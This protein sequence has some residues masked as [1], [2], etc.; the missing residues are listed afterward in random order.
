LSII[1]YEYE[2]CE[3]IIKEGVKRLLQRDLNYLAKYWEY[4]GENRENI[5]KNIEAFCIYNN[6]DFNAIQS[7]EMIYRALNHARNN[8]LRFPT[9]IIITQAEVNTIR[10]LNDYNKEKFLFSM[11]VCAKYFKN[12]KSSK[13]PKK[14]KYD[15]TLYSNTTIKNVEEIARVKY[16]KSEWKILKHE[17]TVKGLISPTIFGSNYWAIGFRNENSE[18]YFTINDYRNLIAY[19]Q[20][21]C[22]EIMINCE[23]C[24]VRTAK[25]SN[26]HRMC[27]TCFTEQQKEFTKKRVR[28]FREKIDM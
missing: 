9:S 11:L 21:Y 6:R 1:F 20:E 15:G 14:S 4:K 24:H 12:H 27:R 25:R 13:H 23:I 8:Y 22:G 19:Y 5:Q 17:F 10:S 2:Y 28:K 16:T 18:P 26:R 7:S 3:K